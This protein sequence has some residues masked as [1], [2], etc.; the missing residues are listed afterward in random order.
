MRVGCVCGEANNT[1]R[2]ARCWNL[3]ETD[4]DAVLLPVRH[5]WS[6][7]S[8][9]YDSL[10][11][12]SGASGK[13]WWEKACVNANGQNPF[14]DAAS[15]SSWIRF[16]GDDG[17]ELAHT[18]NGNQKKGQEVVA[19]NLAMREP[20]T[21]SPGAKKTATTPYSS[22]DYNEGKKESGGRLSLRELINYRIF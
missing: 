13:V 14:E 11:Y 18:D 10:D 22:L 4:W 19:P 16:Y 6:D 21:I 7:T 5:A 2:L 3:C 9:A 8:N 17:E 12:D 20:V 1:L 15:D